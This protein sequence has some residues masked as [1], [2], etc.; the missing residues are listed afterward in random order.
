MRRFVAE[1][2]SL[3][4]RVDADLASRTAHPGWLV[5]SIKEAWPQDFESI[6]DA[7][8]L[9]PPMTLRI[10]LS[11]VH[12]PEYLAQL[13][14]AD[15]AAQAIDWAPAAVQLER[16]AGVFSLPGFK[17][18]RVSV[19][20]AGA[21]LAASL[22]DA[23]SGMRVLDACAAPGGKTG[24]ILER[25]PDLGALL[26]VDI[27]S[28]RM[29]RI[30]DNLQRLGRRAQSVTADI[31]QPASFWDGKPFDR[32]L[33]DAPCSSTGVIR[34]HPDIKLLRRASDIASLAETQLGLLQACFS[35]L[36]AGGRLLYCTCSVLPEENEGVVAR[37]VAEEP[38]ALAVALELKVPEARS[39]T[40]GTQLLPGG[41]AGADG[42]YYACV[43]KT[44][45]GT[46]LA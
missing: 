12:I 10:D 5:Q 31:R 37:F 43:E 21:Q 45:S 20:D 44:T 18:G 19:Q 23:R 29:G 15:I 16:P 9:H 30:R 14:A 3:L 46:P 26:A 39:R 40:L 6:L 35:M 34:R 13:A 4:A 2:S 33:L 32:I 38:E 28:Q 27:D 22:L 41:A 36:A 1:R 24:H 42:F 25:T 17:E 7:N 8:N 11:R